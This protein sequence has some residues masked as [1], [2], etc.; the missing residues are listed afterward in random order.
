MFVC[1]KERWDEVG[2]DYDKARGWRNQDRCAVVDQTLNVGTIL[3]RI[4]ECCVIWPGFAS[5]VLCHFCLLHR[6][7]REFIFDTLCCHSTF[8]QVVS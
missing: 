3:M 6:V 1:Y 4:L 2:G 8:L 5:T 7:R